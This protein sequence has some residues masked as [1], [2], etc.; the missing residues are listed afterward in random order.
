[1]GPVCWLG[2]EDERKTDRER[3]AGWWMVVVLAA[4]ESDG[5]GKKVGQGLS[6]ADLGL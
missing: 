2:L 1:M 5:E 4:R 6:S 3:E